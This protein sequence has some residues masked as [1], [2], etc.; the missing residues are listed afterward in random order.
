MCYLNKFWNRKKKSTFRLLGRFHTRTN[1]PHLHSFLPCLGDFCR[2]FPKKKC[3]SHHWIFFSSS[4]LIKQITLWLCL[5]VQWL[6][7]K[8]SRNRQRF[9]DHYRAESGTTAPC[10]QNTSRQKSQFTPFWRF[11]RLFDRVVPVF[12]D[13]VC[14]PKMQVTTYPTISASTCPRLLCKMVHWISFI[15]VDSSREHGFT[16]FVSHD[17]VCQKKLH[18]VRPLHHAKYLAPTPLGVK[19]A[20]WVVLPF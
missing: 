15:P 6:G 14:S 3:K 18:L 20:F 17:P 16:E 11:L 19:N 10:H 2:V 9:P 1:M 13:A 5:Q 8:I 12:G 7:F 4:M